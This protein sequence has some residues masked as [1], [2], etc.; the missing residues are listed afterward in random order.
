MVIDRRKNKDDVAHLYNGILLSHKK[1]MRQMP[2]A[3]SWMKLD[4]I[5]LNDKSERKDKYHTISLICGI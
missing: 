3:A 5:I 4:T 2:F 1:R